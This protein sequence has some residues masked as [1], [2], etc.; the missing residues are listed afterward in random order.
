MQGQPT[1]DEVREWLRLS[2]DIDDVA[3][4]AGLLAAVEHQGSVLHL[5]TRTVDPC[6][7]GDPVDEP[8]YTDALRLAVMLRTARYLAR[9]NSPEGIIGLGEFGGVQIAVVDRD[10]AALEAPYMPVVAV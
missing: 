1:L 7:G 6:D 10:I 8:Y 9:R 3:L 5:P 2:D 4:Q